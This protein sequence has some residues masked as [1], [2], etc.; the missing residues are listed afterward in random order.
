[1]YTI[2]FTETY[3][4]ARNATKGFEKFA[5]AYE[6][7]SGCQMGR[8]MRRKRIINPF[9]SSDSSDSDFTKK[10][11]QSKLRSKVPKAPPPPLCLPSPSYMT[12]SLNIASKENIAPLTVVSKKKQEKT[13]FSAPTTAINQHTILHKIV[14]LRQQAANKAQ[15]RKEA[16]S[17]ENIYKL[18]KKTIDNTLCSEVQEKIFETDESG[19]SEPQSPSI[20]SPSYLHKHIE[21]HYTRHQSSEML[22]DNQFLSQPI[23]DETQI[24]CLSSPSTSDNTTPK[25]FIAAK[26]RKNKDTD[27]EP[28]ELSQPSSQN[29]LTSQ[30]TLISQNTSTSKLTTSTYIT[31]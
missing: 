25:K 24:L 31:I 9:L 16:M 30:N 3:T 8:G 23:L 11:K 13:A 7:D 26:D 28:D 6:S 27:C 20:L 17:L 18:K 14:N 21:S 4:A 19:K 12:K 2:I 10:S 15:Q 22:N 5:S 29:T 1:L